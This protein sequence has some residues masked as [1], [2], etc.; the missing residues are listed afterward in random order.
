MRFDWREN[1]IIYTRFRR[2]ATSAARLLSSEIYPYYS[3]EISPVKGSLICGGISL[4]SVGRRLE[5]V[6]AVKFM[7][8]PMNRIIEL[9]IAVRSRRAEQ[10]WLADWKGW[11]K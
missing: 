4:L 9:V 8:L 3:D 2:A 7:E 11:S 6:V 10:E 1:T 5:D